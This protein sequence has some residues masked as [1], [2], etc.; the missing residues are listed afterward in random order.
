MRNR[1]EDI[2]GIAN[3]TSISPQCSLALSEANNLRLFPIV[4]QI[5]NCIKAMCNDP[6]II[7]TAENSNYIKQLNY[8]QTDQLWE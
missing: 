8:L 3:M 5:G 7:F 4:Q 1:Q 2:F 6:H